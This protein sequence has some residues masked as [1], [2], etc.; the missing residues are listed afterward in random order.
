MRKQ[1]KPITFDSQ[2]RLPFCKHQT[3]FSCQLQL[4]TSSSA[5]LFFFSCCCCCYRLCRVNWMQIKQNSLMTTL[6]FTIMI[7]KKKKTEKRRMQAFTRKLEGKSQTIANQGRRKIKV[8]EH[9]KSLFLSF[10]V[11]LALISWRQYTSTGSW[12]RI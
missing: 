10:S 5:V 2:I 12:M 11:A 7:I 6:N 8:S 4:H 9:T 3:F 1:Q